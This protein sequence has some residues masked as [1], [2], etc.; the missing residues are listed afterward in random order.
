MTVESPASEHSNESVLAS[1]AY[2]CELIGDSGMCFKLMLIFVNSELF[3]WNYLGEQFVLSVF[4]D[5]QFLCN[6]ISVCTIRGYLQNFSE[7]LFSKT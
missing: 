3:G 2:Q 7:S 6:P 5:L 4:G 1:P